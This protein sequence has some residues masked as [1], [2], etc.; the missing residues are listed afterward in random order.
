[1]GYE[2]IC[3]AA[4]QT[5]EGAEQQVMTVGL[6][7]DLHGIM[8]DVGMVE[9]FLSSTDKL[10]VFQDFLFDGAPSLTHGLVLLGS[11]LLGSALL[12]SALLASV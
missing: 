4:D 6:L 12:G 10:L 8:T 9:L 3:K 2:V 1:M 5:V 11:A 7:V